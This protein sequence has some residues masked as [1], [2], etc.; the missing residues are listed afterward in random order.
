MILSQKLIQ[1]LLNS[2]SNKEIETIMKYFDDESIFI[3]AHYPGT[4]LVGIKNI[5]R[6]L[7]W[8]L[9]NVS[10]MKFTILNCWINDN[11]ASVEVLAEHKLKFGI[12]LNFREIFV[13]ETK[14]EV[15][16]RFEAFLLYSPN[17]FGKLIGNITNLIW[18]IF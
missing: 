17:V 1:T 14:N 12:K 9:K 18:K 6:A 5:R 2:F 10:E 3:D 15:V 8:S 7:E 4:K 16:T 13:I 11:I